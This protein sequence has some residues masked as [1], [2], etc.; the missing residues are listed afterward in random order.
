VKPTELRTLTRDELEQR[1]REG[2]EELFNLKFQHKTGQ[3]ANPLRIRE[4][5]KD[6]ARLATLLEEG[7][8][9]DAS[10]ALGEGREP[11]RA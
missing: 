1:L 7:G 2:R 9:V 6:I 10:P 5:R 4:V 8:T 11:D 3:L